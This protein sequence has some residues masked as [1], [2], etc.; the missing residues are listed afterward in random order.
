MIF[1]LFLTV[2][3][4]ANAVI[5]FSFLDFAQP[6]ATWLHQSCINYSPQNMK[7]VKELNALVCG[8]DFQSLADS[9][10]YIHSGLIHLFVVSGSHLVL[11]QRTL[12][13]FEKKLQNSLQ[14]K[15]K[16][17]TQLLTLLV[18]S[19]LFVYIFICDLNPP[20]V[21]SYLFIVVL[22][23]S[24]KY[25]LQINTQN[26]LLIASLCGLILQPHWITSLS[27][28]MSW[29]AGITLIYID[30][31]YNQSHLLMK[32]FLFY[33][34]FYLTMLFLGLPQVV[35]V[36]IS[37]TISPLLEYILFPLAFLVYIV[38]DLGPLFDVLITVL[39]FVLN[40]FELKPFFRDFNSYLV[41]SLNWLLIFAL[42]FFIHL[43]KIT[44]KVQ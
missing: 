11:I 5:R 36:L 10:I 16:L 44:K 32:N 27:Y 31:I 9:E 22:S 6:L 42:H 24:K 21:R 29:I 13:K 40:Q 17:Q 12:L 37:T 30:E 38:S 8:Q 18:H 3:V 23:F 20:I 2:F 4:L 35:T 1:V 34:H 39:K 33:L 43:M 19:A 14:H 41:I 15:L 7:A 26:A 25:L 28:Q